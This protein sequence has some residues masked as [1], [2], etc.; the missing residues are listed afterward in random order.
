MIP[1]TTPLGVVPLSALEDAPATGDDAKVSGSI[2]AEAGAAAPL[3]VGLYGVGGIGFSGSAAATVAPFVGAVYGGLA[4]SSGAGGDLTASTA[5]AGTSGLASAIAAALSEAGEG[6]GA[7]VVDGYVAGTI[8]D[9]GSSASGSVAVHGVGRA[10]SRVV[11]A[12][13]NSE[14]ESAYLPLNGSSQYGFAANALAGITAADTW[15]TA[16]KLH[17]LAAIANGTYGAWLYAYDATVTPINSLHNRVWTLVQ[18]YLGG[19]YVGKATAAA[20]SVINSLFPGS[21]TLG[22]P[23]VLAVTQSPGNLKMRVITAAGIEYSVDYPYAAGAPNDRDPLHL[24][25]GAQTNESHA[26][27]VPSQM[28]TGKNI[29]VMV[30]MGETPTAELLGW[31]EAYDARPHVSNLRN[32]WPLAATVGSTVPDVV[33]GSDMTLVAI[34]ASSL[35]Q[36]TTPNGGNAVEANAWAI[37]SLTSMGEA[38]GRIFP[39]GITDGAVQVTAHTDSAPPFDGSVAANVSVDAS[40]AGHLGLRATSAALI[41]LAAQLAGDV[42]ISSAHVGA[43]LIA[44]LVSSDAQATGSAGGLEFAESAAVSATEISGSVRATVQSLSALSSHIAVTGTTLAEARLVADTASSL[45]FEAASLSTVKAISTIA[46]A[47]GNLSAQASS[48]SAVGSYVGPDG[49]FTASTFS[50]VYLTSTASSSLAVHVAV[51]GVIIEIAISWL[52]R[53]VAEVTLSLSAST[54]V[55]LEVPG[56][57]T[58]SLTIRGL[59]DVM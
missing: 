8:G 45:V 54:E 23:K 14:L 40:S 17:D 16:I 46:A 32:Y 2:A 18:Y 42:Q 50:T 19:V 51:K 59:T 27:M 53:G 36:T 15:T 58:I 3:R 44:S 20:S 29:G 10:T 35:V 22:V 25:M 34:T 37:G 4:P 9:V 11:A 26:I 55:S 12:A 52:I 21:S 56:S 1:G 28:G 39:A 5:G 47:L 48:V 43:L 24:A 7:I 57:A 49:S 6:L 41:N 13:G 38:G 33:G 31:L 30:A